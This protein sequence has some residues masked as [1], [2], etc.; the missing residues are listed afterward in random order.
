MRTGNITLTI[1]SKLEEVFLVSSAVR[2]ICKETPLS[3]MEVYQVETCVVEA[4]NNAILHAYDNMGGNRVA[5]A[6]ALNDER[7][8]VTVSDCGRTMQGEPGGLPELDFQNVEELPE[9]GW[10]WGIMRAWMDGVS[11]AAAGGQNVLRLVKV[12]RPMAGQVGILG[13]A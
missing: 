12:L 10:G 5:V 9:N 6:V 2:S 3:E 7:L 13:K 11:Y 8:T 4:V 1:E